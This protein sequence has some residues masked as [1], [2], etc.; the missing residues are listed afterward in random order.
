MINTVWLLLV[1]NTSTL[2]MNQ[3]RFDTLPD[4]VKT[5]VMLEA[6]QYVFTK[7]ISVEERID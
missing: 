1:L 3:L 7:C 2:E 4:C 6:Q 5:G